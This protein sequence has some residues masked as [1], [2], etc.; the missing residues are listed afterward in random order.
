MRSGDFDDPWPCGVAPSRRTMGV[1]SWGDPQWF[2][3]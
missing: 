3:H 1:T 2:Q